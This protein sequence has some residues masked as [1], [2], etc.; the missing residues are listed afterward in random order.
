MLKMPPGLNVIRTLCSCYA[1]N[2][3]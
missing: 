1:Y 3:T 2:A